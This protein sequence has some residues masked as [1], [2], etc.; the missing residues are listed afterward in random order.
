MK[1][2]FS[3]QTLLVLLLL[4]A[5][6]FWQIREWSLYGQLTFGTY[7]PERLVDELAAGR[8]VLVFGCAQ[9]DLNTRPSIHWNSEHVREQLRKSRMPLLLADWTN[10]DPGVTALLK[11]HGVNTI[12]VIFAFHPDDP[13][14]PIILRDL[15]SDSRML[16]LIVE[17]EH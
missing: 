7:S 2:H 5:P 6:V 3:L 17:M 15:V 12:P 16:R 10:Q 8:S 13:R 14:H 1:L 11:R 4:L 9:W